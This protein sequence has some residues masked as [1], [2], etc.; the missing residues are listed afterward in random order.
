[1]IAI[2]FFLLVIMITVAIT[3]VASQRTRTADDFYVAG[4]KV[5]GLANG[6]AIAGDFMSAATLLGI[7]AIIFNAGFDAAI[8]LGA[9][10]A[11]FS[12]MIFLMTD[13]LQRLGRYTFTDIVVARLKERPIRILVAITTLAFSIMYLMVQVV[14][15]GAL[16]QVLFGIDYGWAVLIVTALMVLYVAVGG[17]IATTWV[18]ITKA[19]MLLMGITVL[20]FLS[21][22]AFDFEFAR[23]YAAANRNFS[24]DTKVMTPGGLGLSTLSALSLGL[25]LCFGLAGSPHLLMR[26]FTV[27]NA[28][29]ARQSAGVAL[30]AVAFVNVL[31]FF[32]IGIAA[33]AIVKDNPAYLDAA[34]GVVGGA[35]MVSVHLAQAVGGDVFF[36]IMAAVAFATILA[37]VAGL[38]LACVSA[39]THD[40]YAKVIKEDAVDEV[41]QLKLSRYA[42]LVIGVMVSVLGILFEGQNIAYLVSLALTIGASTNFPLLMLSMYWPGLTTRGAIWGGGVGLVLSVVLIGLGPGVWVRV[43]GFATPVLSEAYPAIYSILFAFATMGLVSRFDRSLQGKTDRERFDTVMATHG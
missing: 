16:I 2:S 29:A 38:T 15:A 23:L 17:M 27:P 43:L 36:G 21:L 25:S 20:A 35:N 22:K 7:S 6:L 28:K 34:G 5:G 9:P 39:I 40:L 12:I 13:K 1:M 14:G 41:E 37:V 31:L 10:L 3:A 8:Y 24:T 11:A 30:G 18:Q 19:V 32:V 4:G 42:T 33:I 26:F